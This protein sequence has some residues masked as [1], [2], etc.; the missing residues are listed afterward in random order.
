MFLGFA[1]FSFVFSVKMFCRLLAEIQTGTLEQVYLSPLRAWLTAA[2]GRLVAAM[3]ETAFVV[4]ALSLASAL[5]TDL[6][7]TWIAEV[8]AP[9]AFVMAGGAG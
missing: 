1:V 6:Q 8:L 5:I 9:I 4:G 7:I 2:V 3:V